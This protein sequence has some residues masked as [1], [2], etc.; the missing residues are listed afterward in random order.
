MSATEVTRKLP[1]GR[2]LI[3]VGL[4]RITPASVPGGLFRLQ[5]IDKVRSI[6][7]SFSDAMKSD[8]KQMVELTVNREHLGAVKLALLELWGGQNS[9][10]G[11][12]EQIADVSGAG[13]LKIWDKHIVPFLPKEEVPAL[14]EL[15]DE[16]SLTDSDD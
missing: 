8:R 11:I 7:A 2:A 13:G 4:I 3:L 5:I 1:Y 16:P 9:N 10:G 14:A 12:Q 15:D 6:E